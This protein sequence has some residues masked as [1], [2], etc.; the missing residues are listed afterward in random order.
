MRC[1]RRVFLAAPTKADELALQI[2]PASFQIPACAEVI[3]RI[4]LLKQTC[5]ADALQE[6]QCFAWAAL[7]DRRFLVARLVWIVRIKRRAAISGQ[8][9]SE[10]NQ[11]GF[12]FLLRH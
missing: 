4:G 2:F 7:V 3:Q 11:F 1:S 10:A 6:I 8:H 9:S 5:V 12:T